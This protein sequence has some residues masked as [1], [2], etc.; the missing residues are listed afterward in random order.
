[1]GRWHGTDQRWSRGLRFR[2]RL[3]K[4]QFHDWLFTQQT[5]H[6]SKTAQHWI[7]PIVLPAPKS[8]L[9]VARRRWLNLETQN[10]T[11]P[12]IGDSPGKFVDLSIYEPNKLPWGT[13]SASSSSSFAWKASYYA[14]KDPIRFEANLSKTI[15]LISKPQDIEHGKRKSDEIFLLFRLKILFF[16]TIKT[17]FLGSL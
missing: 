8:T 15:P 10:Q 9:T 4:F 17:I 1:M 12:A 2:N 7:R 11:R 5:R 16:R 13:D 3:A 6:A 14:R